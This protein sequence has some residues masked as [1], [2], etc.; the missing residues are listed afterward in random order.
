MVILGILLVLMLAAVVAITSTEGSEKEGS[1]PDQ[2]AA[3]S[4]LT[5]NEKKWYKAIKE[6]TP[7]VHVFGQV[8]L[9]QLVKAEGR[10]WQAAKNK[11]ATRSIDFVILN[12]ELVVTLAIEI[13]DRSHLLEKRKVDDEKKNHAL[14]QAG[15]PLLRIP[16]TPVLSSEE[17]KEKIVEILARQ[18]KAKQDTPKMFA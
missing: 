5:E 10:T 11:I 6:A 18:I 4:L 14:R 12:S 16:A 15:I 9:N 3:K 8:A 2:Y 1:N 13:D 7:N 17:V